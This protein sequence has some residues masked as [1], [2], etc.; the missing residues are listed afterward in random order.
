MKAYLAKIGARGGAAKSP[1]KAAA[2]AANGAKGGRPKG[3]KDSKP[4]TR[5][6]AN[7]PGA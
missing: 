5:S 3:A 7:K 2:S 6:P 1:T 4:R